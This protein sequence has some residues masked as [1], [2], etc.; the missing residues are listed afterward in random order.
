MPAVSNLPAET[1]AASLSRR[2]KL[3]ILGVVIAQF[4]VGAGPVWRRPFDWD[5][6][7]LWSYA[8]IP[9]LVAGA[10][11][12]RRRLRWRAWLLDTAEVT[13]M[14][15]G[16]TALFLVV[17]LLSWELRGGQRPPGPGPTSPG[18]ESAPRAPRPPDTRPRAPRT[19]SLQGTAPPGALVFVS[20]G[21][22]G[23]SF[24]APP[25]ESLAHDGRG[26]FPRALGVQVGQVLQLRS[27]DGR[28]HTMLAKKVGGTW[29]RNA[30]ITGGGVT[31]LAFDEPVGVVSL[32][33]KVHGAAEAPGVMAILDHPLWAVAGADG[34]FALEGVP[35]GEGELTA[36]VPGGGST[37]A[38]YRAVAG[39]RAE[40][41]LR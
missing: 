32:E 35:P 21:V 13:A 25:P 22:E 34:R 24:E 23:W 10:L 28:L 40:V 31:Q 1:S 20:R 18:V 16:F 3:A 6:S 9:F 12:W 4:L 27:A 14:K 39:Q 29:V 5:A 11:L 33:C 19:A 38:P 2:D 15:F 17:W 37:T 41:S 8:T 30:P 26:Y 7:I 36:V